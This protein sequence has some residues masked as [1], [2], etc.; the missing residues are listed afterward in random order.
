MKYALRKLDSDK[1]SVL[2]LTENKVVGTFR[3][4][5][6]IRFDKNRKNEYV[7]L[8]HYIGKEEKVLFVLPINDVVRVEKIKN[9]TIEFRELSNSKN[10]IL[11]ISNFYKEIYD[12]NYV[13]NV[14][15][16]STTQPKG[17]FRNT[18][19]NADDKVYIPGNL[20]IDENVEIF[21]NIN[22][23]DD[24]VLIKT[25]DSVKSLSFY[26]LINVLT[27]VDNKRKT[28]WDLGITPSVDESKFGTNPK[29]Q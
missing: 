10:K 28:I 4:G 2:N 16:S 9:N 20:K 15:V 17:M 6:K 7:T 29:W 24:M 25:V 27:S 3:N 26:D 13:N 23:T 8:Y 21:E 12:L 5:V 11:T 19:S 22:L 18:Q 14:S 1:Y